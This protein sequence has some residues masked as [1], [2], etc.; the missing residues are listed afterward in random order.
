[1]TKFP[2]T[3]IVEFVTDAHSELITKIRQEFPHIRHTTDKW[4]CLKNMQNK[5]RSSIMAK[6]RKPL[7][8]IWEKFLGWI[9]RAIETA[10]E[11]KQQAVDLIQSSLLHF[12]G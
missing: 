7:Q 10:G 8:P 5:Y 2:S 6:K 1:M 11:N 12:Q 3:K 9:W 4:H